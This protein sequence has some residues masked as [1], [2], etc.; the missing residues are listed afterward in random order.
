MWRRLS[1][2]LLVCLCCAVRG[3]SAQEDTLPLPTAGEEELSQKTDPN[4]PTA[5]AEA[6]AEAG[7][8][9]GE[10]RGAPRP[11]AEPL[12]DALDNQE[13]IISQVRTHCNHAFLLNGI[14]QFS[15]ILAYMLHI[16][17]LTAGK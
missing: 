2:R 6:K 9:G 7:Q 3:L 11:T 16:I 4:A 13:N 15:I 8:Q 10:R 5:A 12:K 17:I 14:F 1:V